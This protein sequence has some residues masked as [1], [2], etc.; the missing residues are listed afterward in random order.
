MNY[1]KT[2]SQFK[3]SNK[4]SNVTYYIYEP[5][6]DIRGILQISHG[7]CEYIER[8]EEF[9]DYMTSQ[10]IL[11][12]GNDHLGHGNS[13]NSDDDLGYFAPKNGWKCLVNDLKFLSDMIKDKY[14]YVPFFILGHS[15]GSFL[16]RAYISK[17]GSDLT[18]IIISGTGGINPLAG[19]GEFLTTKMSKIKGSRYRSKLFNKIFFHG[20]NKGIKDDLSTF[21]WLTH[22][23]L[24]VDK[25]TNDFKCNYIFTLNGFLNLIKVQR[26][27]TD[28]AW[29]DTVP[30]ELP[31]LII[32]GDKDPVGNWGKGVTS[33]YN[34]LV[35]A[36][37]VDITLKLYKD[38][39]HEMLNEINRFEVFDDIE[40]WM[41]QYIL[42]H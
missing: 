14:P 30:K 1:K 33:T 42:P 9:I 25:Y 18:G 19:F 11:V 7:M 13:I 26:L 2:C 24:I 36:N 17:Y 38:G 3:S 28:K 41:N 4:V 12:F 16:L 10:G 5:A 27:T 29:T 32:S 37:I 6:C 22:D 34:N 39:R 21:A 40:K 35:K 31:I 15:M 23:K 8:Y 20:F